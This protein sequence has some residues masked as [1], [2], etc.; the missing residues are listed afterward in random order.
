MRVHWLQHVPFEG[1]GSIEAW[2]TAHN[3]SITCS[4]LWA[5]DT[6]PESEDFDWLIVMG[7]PMNVDDL[8]GYPWL[9]P[10]LKLI[11]A[12][13]AHEKTVLGICLGAQLMARA[14]G[15][16]VER[17]DPA[18]IGWF[19]VELTNL[20]AQSPIFADF[21]ASFTGF[22]W[23]GDRFAIPT[24]AELIA[25]S[26]ACNNQ[27]FIYGKR[28]LG[29]QFHLETTPQSAAQ[30]VQHCGQE[31]RQG[32]GRDGGRDKFVQTA[33]QILARPDQFAALNK[34]MDSLLSRLVQA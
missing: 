12:A 23:H 2:L 22:H 13:L 18:E 9:E 5:G 19:E 31:L 14:L 21:E 30:L 26:Q 11:G 25:S 10:E 8:A 20:G 33:E 16:L 29:L 34:L 24:G 28:A 32:Q 17:G 15:A 6:L 7:G 27:A 1:L 3:Y 4:R